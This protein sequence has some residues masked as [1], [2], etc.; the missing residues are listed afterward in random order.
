MGYMARG[1]AVGDV[2][3]L[4]VVAL[5]EDMPR[6]KLLRGQVGTVV[7]ILAT[8]AFEVEFGAQPGRNRVVLA[9]RGHQVSV[10]NKQVSEET[11][12]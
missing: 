10:L 5:T 4:D 11:L 6:H 2:Q 12:H 7:E 9:L 1:K 3:V 8:G